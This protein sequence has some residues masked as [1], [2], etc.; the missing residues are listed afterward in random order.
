LS[1]EQERRRTGLKLSHN[2]KP[3]TNSKKISEIKQTQ[4]FVQD[5]E[6]WCDPDQAERKFEFKQA[7]RIILV[8]PTTEVQI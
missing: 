3:L 1:V 6:P 4:G 8:N 2:T 5:L 7:T